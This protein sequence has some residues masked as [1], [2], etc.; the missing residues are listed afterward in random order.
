MHDQLKICGILKNCLIQKDGIDT[1]CLKWSNPKTNITEFNFSSCS[2]RIT[3]TDVNSRPASCLT[4][5][6]LSGRCVVLEVNNR[7]NS[8]QQQQQRISSHVL[9]A[10]AGEL[11]MHCLNCCGRSNLDDRPSIE[12]VPAKLNNYR[13]NEFIEF[14][15][16]NSLAANSIDSKSI[17]CIP[18]L[19][20]KNLDKIEKATRKWPI[21]Y[22][23]SLI[24][25]LF[26]TKKLMINIAEE[27]L[28]DAQFTEC[29]KCLEY[30][31]NCDFKN[32]IYIVP[33]KLPLS[34]RSPL[35]DYD[36]KTQF[37]I[38]LE[39]WLKL[40]NDLSERHKILHS[41]SKIIRDQLIKTIEANSNN[42]GSN[43]TSANLTKK[44]DLDM[45]KTTKSKKIEFIETR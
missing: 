4:Q 27:T 38:E 5:F 34:G 24:S 22:N 23:D 45:Y 21:T 17:N 37:W 39:M 33:L 32:E 26:Q 18:N 6:L 42:N 19:F 10:H 29:I 16:M 31:Q 13:I 7:N 8:Q 11:F 30:F 28:S 12:N 1:V 9:C 3:P 14:I 40:F 15:K 43:K 2:Y 44:L 35:Y 36:L 20:Q 25:N 41:H